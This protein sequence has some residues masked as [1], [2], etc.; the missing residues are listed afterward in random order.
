MNLRSG[1]ILLCRLT[2]RAPFGFR[3]ING[4]PVAILKSDIV[5][6]SFEYKLFE[7]RDGSSD[8]IIR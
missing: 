2:L 5:F 6:L 4:H 1:G 3:K 8:E 7:C